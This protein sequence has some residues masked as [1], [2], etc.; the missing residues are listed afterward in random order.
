MVDLVSIIIPVYNAHQYL[1]A[2]INSVNNQTY[3]NVEVIVVDDGS[4]QKTKNKIQELSTK[5]DIILTQENKGQSTARN[6]GVKNSKGK[7][8][9]F[10]DSDDFV[11]KDFCEKLIINYSDNYASITSYANIIEKKKKKN[12]FKPKGG[13]IKEVLKN[14]IALGTS[15]FLKTEFDA[16]G[17]YDEKMKTGF[18]DWEML[19]R[20]LANTKKDVFV[21][22]NALYNYRKGIIS[23]TTKANKIKYDLLKYI[24]YKH[25]DLYKLYFKDFVD[26]LLN[27]IEIEEKQKLKAYEKIDYKIG[28]FILKPLRFIKKI[29]NG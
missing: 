9:I 10:I 4:N 22:E 19:I 6:V 24:Y 20:L 29:I 5:I 28:S 15:L 3:A 18:E 25:E 23:T 17:G 7:F 13:G 11:E 21:V 12:I 16:I 8:I 26:F 27:K 14:N 1:E 2:C